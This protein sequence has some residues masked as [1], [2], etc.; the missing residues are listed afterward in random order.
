MVVFFL[1]FFGLQCPFLRRGSWMWSSV[2]CQ[3]GSV[4]GTSPPTASLVLFAEVSPF[5]V[6]VFKLGFFL[7]RFQAVSKCL[8]LT[9]QDHVGQ[10]IIPHFPLPPAISNQ[11]AFLN[12]HFVRLY[13][14]TPLPDQVCF[15]AYGGCQEPVTHFRLL[16]FTHPCFFSAK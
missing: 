5:V 9:D 6:A 10:F 1:V 11:L 8:V 14:R 16:A 12:V 7:S 15:R 4:Q 3:P 13:P 2:S